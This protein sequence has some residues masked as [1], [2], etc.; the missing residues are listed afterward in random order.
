R[1]EKCQNQAELIIAKQRHGPVGTVKTHF[2]GRFTKF[3]N[4]ARERDSF[5]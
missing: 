4:L 2:E 3:S 5:F 1:I